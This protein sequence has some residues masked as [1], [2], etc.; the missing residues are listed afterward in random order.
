M[1]LISG[2]KLPPGAD[3]GRLRALAAK[4]LRIPTEAVTSLNIRKK[5]LDARKKTDIHSVYTVC[6]SVRG[7]EAKLCARCKQ[8]SI[9]ADDRSRIPWVG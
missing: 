7:D 4:A 3:E 6:I 9:A 1:I 5:S 2:L 8:A